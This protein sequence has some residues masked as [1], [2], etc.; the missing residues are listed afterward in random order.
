MLAAAWVSKD[1]TS[2]LLLTARKED[3]TMKKKQ[4]I[5]PEMT[6]VALAH[7]GYLLTISGDVQNLL[8]P[9]GEGITLDADGI[10]AGEFDV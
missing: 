2:V 7:Q 4:Y 10:D 5:N 1:R 8:V 9:D 6:V 3:M